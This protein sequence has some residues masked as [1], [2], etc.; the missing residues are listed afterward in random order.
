MRAKAKAKTKAEHP[1]LESMRAE[2]ALH[3]PEMFDSDVR[4]DATNLAKLPVEQ[5][6]VWAIY[7][8][9]TYLNTSAKA[10]HDLAYHDLTCMDKIGMWFRIYTWDGHELTLMRRG[11]GR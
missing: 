9:G 10:Y 4:C 1:A 5:C 2:I 11:T 8:Q 3:P 6:F 7:K